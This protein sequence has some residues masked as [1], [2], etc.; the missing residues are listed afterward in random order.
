MDK[1]ISWFKK[2]WYS[3]RSKLNEVY[4]YGIIVDYILPII[5][6][7]VMYYTNMGFGSMIKK[8]FG[9]EWGIT[10]ALNT[11]SM[12]PI[13]TIKVVVSLN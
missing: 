1:Y 10:W 11:Q 6:K 3:T 9:K 12:D 5:K 2:V 4:L 7:Y 8:S 13:H